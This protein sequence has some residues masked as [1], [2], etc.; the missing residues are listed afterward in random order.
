VKLVLNGANITCSNSA[1]IFIQEADKTVVFLADGRSNTLQDGSTYV[2]DAEGD[3]N[4]VLFSKDDLTISGGGT[5]TITANYNDGITSKDGLVIDGGNLK[6]TATD[7]GIRG[8][9]YLI[10]RNGTIHVTAG[11]DGLLSDEEDDVTKGFV[12]LENGTFTIVAGGDG[13]AAQTDALIGNGSVSITSGGGS[14]KTVVGDA[15]AKGIKGLVACLLDG[16]TITINSAD[17]ALHTHNQMTIQNASVSIS[18]NDDAA[19]SEES[20]IVNSGVMA[21]SKSY[22]GL[23][24]RTLTINGGEIRITSTDDGINGAG[25]VDNSAYSHFMTAGNAVFT[26]NGGYTAVTA[27]GDG[28]D[29]NGSITMTGGTLLVHGPTE[30][31]NGALDYDSSFKISGGVLIA[32]GSSGMAQAPGSTSTQNSVLINLTSTLGA[33]TLF[34]IRSSSGEGI[35]TFAPSK[36]YQSIAYSSAALANGSTY[37]I[38][39]SGSCT[40]KPQ[41]GLYQS[42]TY[43]AGTKYADF[44]VSSAVTTVGTSFGMGGPGMMGGR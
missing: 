26:V 17:D 33:N 28:I 44:T 6:I 27:A 4:A 18:S 36:K 41:D 2:L 10:I 21:I 12:F 13:I 30:S 24:A 5:L 19:H 29:I 15:S 14:S 11:G 23:E 8:K 3:P 35:L 43:T 34:H 42:G 1:P 16:G 22:E 37:E 9:D 25:G 38:Y 31:M 7:D 20:L 40:G 39:S 32:A